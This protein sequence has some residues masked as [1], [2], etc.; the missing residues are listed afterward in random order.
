MHQDHQCRAGSPNAERVPEKPERLRHCRCGAAAHEGA[1][2][3]LLVSSPPLLSACKYATHILQLILLCTHPSAGQP[4]F[5][6]GRSA[7]QS[8]G[9]ILRRVCACRE[10]LEELNISWCRGVPEPWLGVLADA[11]T[12]LRKLTVFGCSQAGFSSGSFFQ[13]SVS[14]GCL[15]LHSST[16]LANQ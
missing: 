12:C 7:A 9:M 14:G 10:S 6:A 16:K 11:C 13:L 3:L 2:R 1:G 8:L 15:G 5:K 4:G